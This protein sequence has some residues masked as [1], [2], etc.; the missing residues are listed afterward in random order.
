MSNSRIIKNVSEI[1]TGEY[2]L[3][4]IHGA[5]LIERVTPISHKDET[6]FITVEDDSIS[7]EFNN[8]S[9][10]IQT[11]DFE[12]FRSAIEDWAQDS[13]GYSKWQLITK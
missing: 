5:I 11:Y 1:K 10:S 2:T 12:E 7:V 8:D 3:R 9:R 6:V 13:N 4:T